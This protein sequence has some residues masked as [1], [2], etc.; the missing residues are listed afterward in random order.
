MIAQI[1]ITI[2]LIGILFIVTYRGIKLIYEK[3]SKMEDKSRLDQKK[4]DLI[5]KERE[6]E[7]L[8]QEVDVEGKLRGIT[9][10]IES[11]KKK[12]IKFDKKETK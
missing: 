8:K 4:D 9:K 2:F 7:D 3:L 6:L 5:K 12:F 11:C 10:D 1:I